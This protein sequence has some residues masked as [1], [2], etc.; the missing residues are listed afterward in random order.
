MV[1][2]LL[3][4]V[5]CYASYS[6]NGQIEVAYLRNHAF[7]K[8]EYTKVIEMPH[9]KGLYFSQFFQSFDL[10]FKASLECS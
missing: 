2:L 4:H 3:P 8:V 1:G 10:G 6:V 7:L 9:I 5:S